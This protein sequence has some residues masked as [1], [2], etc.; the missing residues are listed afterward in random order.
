M[1]PRYDAEGSP[2][3][4][5]WSLLE[6]L[7]ACLSGVGA[8]AAECQAERELLLFNADDVYQRLWDYG[9]VMLERIDR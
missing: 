1:A 3:N 8:T 5:F 4:G 9:V 2:G 6:L 7:H